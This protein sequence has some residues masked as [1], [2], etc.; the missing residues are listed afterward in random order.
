MPSESWSMEITSLFVRMSRTSFDT[1]RRSFPAINGAANI[2]HK[3]KWAR[4]SLNVR[5]P[6]PTSSISGSFQCPGPA[7]LRRPFCISKMY[8]TPHELYL[9]PCAS[10]QSQ[11]EVMSSVVLQRWPTDPAHSHGLLLPHSHML[12]TIGLF[13]A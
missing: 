7:Y 1:F 8:I 11:H 4:L 3:E 2:A 13:A 6:F 10:I 9:P 12:N 5:L